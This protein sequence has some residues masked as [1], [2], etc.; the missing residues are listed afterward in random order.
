MAHLAAVTEAAK[1]GND[2]EVIRLASQANPFAVSSSLAEQALLTACEFGQFSV[3]RACIN[4]IKCNP[5]CVDKLG[6]SPLHMAVYRKGNGKVAVSIIKFLVENGAKLRKSVLHVCANDLA[7]HAL[8]NLKADINA[9]SVDGLTPIAAAVAGDRLEIVSELIR[10]GALLNQELV[11]SIKGTSVAKELVRAKVDINYKNSKGLTA[12]QKAVESNDKRLA[13]SLLEAKADPLLV[14][15]AP[16]LE[17]ENACGS[18]SSSQPSRSNSIVISVSSD[19][20]MKGLLSR[21]QEIRSLVERAANSDYENLLS[22]DMDDWL[23]IERGLAKT[24]A[25]INSVKNTI[26]QHNKEISRGSMCVVC[27][28]RVKS[29]VLMPCKHLCCCGSCL[30]ALQ[31]GGTWE[32]GLCDSQ[33]SAG[34]SK[35]QCPLC[36]SPFDEA[37]NVFT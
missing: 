22:S 16:S 20:T 15:R 33:L 23:E 1:E 24:M 13:R 36:R 14:S 9:K 32:E 17:D 11:F 28:T 31:R 35:P 12:L 25:D 34:N 26:E 10:M 30:K 27:R 29:V 4:E 6:R 19:Y 5:N 7:V 18:A 21:I 37:V 8:I 3:V 2:L